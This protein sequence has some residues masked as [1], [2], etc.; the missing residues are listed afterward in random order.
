MSL[1]ISLCCGWYLIALVFEIIIYVLL[2]LSAEL[3]W[4][5]NSLTVYPCI[6]Y[7]CILNYIQEQLPQYNDRAWQ[8]QQHQPHNAPMPMGPAMTMG[9]DTHAPMNPMDARGNSSMRNNLYAGP[10]P[11]VPASNNNSMYHNGLDYNTSRPTVKE[12]SR[13][14]SPLLP[15]KWLAMLSPSLTVRA[16]W[17]GWWIIGLMYYVYTCR[18][19]LIVPCNGWVRMNWAGQCIWFP[20]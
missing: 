6:V 7:A 11:A 9:L 13:R 8:P 2:R 16:L 10:V 5:T 14:T 4:C 1:H 17:A 18:V 20:S 15:G 3:I 19:Q 12:P